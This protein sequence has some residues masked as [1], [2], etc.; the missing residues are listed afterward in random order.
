MKFLTDLSLYLHVP[1]CKKKCAYCDFYSG[2]V[3]DEMLDKYTNS[4][5][6][7]VKQWGGKISRPIDTL[8]LGGG[9]PSLLN[10]RILPLLNAVRQNFKVK[11]NAEITLECNP[12]PNIKEI[13]QNAKKAGVNRISIGAQSGNDGMLK[14]LGRTHK[15]QDVVNAVNVARSLNFSN[16]SLDLM[17]GLPNSDLHTLKADLDFITNLNPEHVSAYI[18][19]IEPQTAFYK[20]KSSLNL[21]DDDS[22][23]DQYLFM[24]EY[25]EQRGFSH[26][27]IS[28]FCKEGKHSAHNLKYWRCE[29]Y[30]GLGPSAHSFLCGKRFFYPKD[31]KA[32]LNGNQPLPDG[33]GGE[34]AEQI[35]LRLRLKEGIPTDILPKK[36]LEKCLEF[37]KHRLVNMQNG[38]LWLT[39]KGMLVS[40][41]IITEITEVF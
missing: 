8:Y 15:A 6:E 21:P 19:K 28:N 25:L 39:D 2:V 16:V 41:A 35:M 3:T 18:L 27:E 22:V 20:L 13:L 24:C 32:F 30:L 7:S 11:E 12:Q 29:E 31:L 40:N 37:Q 34:L 23:S 5:I 10:H 14:T 17:I 9:T 36:A 33:T 1:F 26:Y 38:R 4:L